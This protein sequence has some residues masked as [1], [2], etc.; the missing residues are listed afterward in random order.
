M[1]DIAVTPEE[2]TAVVLRSLPSRARWVLQGTPL[3]YDFSAG[4]SGV[5]PPS[6][7]QLPPEVIDPDARALLIFGEYDFAQGGGANPFLGVRSSD[8]AV[9]GL[10]LERED[11]PLF[12]LNSSIERFVRTFSL[13]DN[14]LARGGAAPADI[15]EQLA[16]IDPEAYGTSEWRDLVNASGTEQ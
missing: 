15:D 2:V 1:T 12:P 4:H 6:T 8:G 10:D 9:L 5:R 13:L 16:A 11:S 7:E 3:D 14:Y